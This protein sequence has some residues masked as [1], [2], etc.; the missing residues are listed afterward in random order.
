ML[1]GVAIINII[2]ATRIT[3]LTNISLFVNRVIVKIS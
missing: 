1:L 3:L 2:G